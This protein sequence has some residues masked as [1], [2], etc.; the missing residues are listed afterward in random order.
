MELSYGGLGVELGVIPKGEMKPEES[1][2]E[3]EN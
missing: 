2:K 3:D 1:G